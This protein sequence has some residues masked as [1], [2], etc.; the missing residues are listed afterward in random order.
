MIYYKTNEEIELMRQSNLLVSKTLAHIAE[1][2]KV[3]KNS[4]QIDKSAEEFIKDHGGKPGFKGYRG[5][6]ATLCMSI[7]DAVVHG[8]P[9]DR[10]FT[11]T[12]IV[13]IDCGVVLNGFY[14]DAAFTFAFKNITPEV[15]RLLKVTRESLYKGISAAVIGNRVGDISFHI[16]H[17]C[18]KIHGYSIVRE[19]V[20]HGVGRNLH[21]DPEVPNFGQ[22]GKGPILKDGLV[23]AIEPMVNLGV[24]GVKQLNDGWTILTKDGKPS[25]HYE[26][27]VAIRKDGPD[28]LSD[29]S[30]IDE[31]IKKND[32][33][34]DISINL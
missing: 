27:S 31:S 8:I 33:I 3:G 7:N 10:V 28:I 4:K 29:H 11:E 20:G 15:R 25:A 18:E 21:E 2:L 17:Y 13:S 16:Q 22:R 24:R 32:E 23:L 9:S 26:H 19:L 14:G 6:P 30:Y 1:I 34:V 5:F 12:D